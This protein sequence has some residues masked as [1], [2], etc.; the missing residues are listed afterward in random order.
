MTAALGF[1]GAGAVLGV[2][3][4]LA[5]GPLTALVL[6]QTLRHGAREGVKVAMAPLLTD[7]PLLVAS[8]LAVSALAEVDAVLAGV[9][10]VGAAYLAW[11][12]WET[13]HA[14]LPAAAE[15]EGH[16]GSVRKAVLTNV[17]NPHAWLFWIAVGGPLVHE[18]WTGSGLAVAG[19]LVGFFG[20]LCGSK[21]GLGIA[22]G[23]VRHRIDGRLYRGA[24]RVLALLLAAFAVGFAREAWRLAG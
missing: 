4:G 8:A 15:A 5:P 20:G 9:S 14:E 10:L 2:S 6:T 19:F 17:L 22:V 24:M 7:G 16:P 13:W 21:A 1:L 3:G 12:A 23:T 18:A 11:L